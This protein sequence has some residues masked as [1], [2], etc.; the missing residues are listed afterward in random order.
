MPELMR[1]ASVVYFASGLL[2]A[3]LPLFRYREE[4]LLEKTLNHRLKQLLSAAF[5][6][7]IV[8]YG[9]E[10]IY[11]LLDRH[12]MD[13]H[14]ADMLPQIEVSARRWLAGE[15]VYVPIPEIWNGLLP[16]YLP[17]MWIPYAPLIIAEIDIRWT[18]VIFFFAGCALLFWMLIRYAKVEWLQLIMILVLLGFLVFIQTDYNRDFFVYSQEGLVVAYYIFLGYAL[19][20]NNAWL[21]GIAIT[22]CLLSRYA[23]FFWIPSFLLFQFFTGM[24]RQALI[25]G[26]VV[27]ILTSILFIIPYF[28]KNPFYFLGLPGKYVKEVAYFWKVDRDKIMTSLGLGKFFSVDQLPLLHRVLMI[29]AVSVPLVFYSLLFR[30]RKSKIINLKFAGIAGLKLTLVFFYNFIEAP[31]FQYLFMVPAF[32]SYTILL[33]FFT[34][35]AHVK[36]RVEYSLPV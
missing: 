26:I 34:P 6:I 2:I 21:M 10:Q 18:T 29:T 13:Y 23:L 4:I 3:L 28:L 30:F 22:M 32:F 25:T 7:V 5:F 33:H 20:R 11:W 14:M 19:S 17:M 12:K 27:F 1:V 35:N 15:E 8:V 31:Q 9:S 24:K 16:T 36:A